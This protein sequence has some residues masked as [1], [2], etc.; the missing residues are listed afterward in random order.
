MLFIKLFDGMLQS[1]L[2]VWAV[3]RYRF[4]AADTNHGGYKTL[5]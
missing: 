4:G 3:N 5:P 1:F 2:Q